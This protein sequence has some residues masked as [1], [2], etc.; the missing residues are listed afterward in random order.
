ML[1]YNYQIYNAFSLIR[2]GQC[3]IRTKVSKRIR[4]T[5]KGYEIGQINRIV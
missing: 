4:D 3:Y 5:K 2:P 1:F